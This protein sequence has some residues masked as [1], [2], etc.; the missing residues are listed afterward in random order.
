MTRLG[1][2]HAAALGD[3]F[4]D[5]APKAGVTRVAAWLAR[6]QQSGRGAADQRALRSA[7]CTSTM[8]GR[9]GYR[10]M[11]DSGQTTTRVA[12]L[13]GPA[14]I[15]DVRRLLGARWGE[16]YLDPAATLHALHAIEPVRLIDERLADWLF[17]RSGWAPDDRDA[18]QR[19]QTWGLLADIYLRDLSGLANRARQRDRPRLAE[20]I[21][22][23]LD[24]LIDR[25]PL[26]AVRAASHDRGVLLCGSHAG[27]FRIGR[28]TLR[29][30]VPGLFTIGAANEGEG[31]LT[32][33]DPVRA[34]Y[35]FTKHLR[36]SDAVGLIGA[37]GGYGEAVGEIT[38]H[39][40]PLPIALGPPTIVRGAR[41][42]AF[43]FLARWSADRIRLDFTPAPTVDP[44][45]PAATWNAIW[46][47]AYAQHLSAIV[48]GAP[49]NLRGTS[50]I[51]GKIEDALM[52][53]DA[54][55]HR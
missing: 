32:T 3:L 15:A 8:K 49:E 48:T 52:R 39:G 20:T 7:L 19:R 47:D 45:M 11:I 12:V 50:G 33:A 42:P 46:L 6:A 41:C 4:A 5:A 17:C 13:D 25:T 26:D 29:A 31:R 37:D 18:W 16:A 55:D 1:D 10:R 53:A 9:R 23:G 27:A 36:Q 2:L 40:L 30:A 34:L 38:V 14:G 44:A 54:G 22:R 43:F 51:W 28:S 35:Q 24:T 21:E